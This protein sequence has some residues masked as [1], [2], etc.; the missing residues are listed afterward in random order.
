M[1]TASELTENLKLL[2]DQLKKA[3]AVAVVGSS[4]PNSKTLLQRN[5]L[6]SEKKRLKE[7]LQ[8]EVAKIRDGKLPKTT[9]KKQSKKADSIP[10]VTTIEELV[11]KQVDHFIFDY[12]GKERWCRG[13]VVERKPETE[14]E[15]VIR[16]DY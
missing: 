9:K 16:Y 11:G 8:N 4:Q 14:S 3:V 6:E 1:K 10:I 13:T 7:L 12:D 15:L 2:I 5:E